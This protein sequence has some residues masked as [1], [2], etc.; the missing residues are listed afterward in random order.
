MCTPINT[1][2]IILCH[3]G[4]LKLSSESGD[5]QFSGVYTFLAKYV[6][7]AEL[8]FK[9]GKGTWPVYLTGTC[10]KLSTLLLHELVLLSSSN[11]TYLWQLLENSTCARSA[12]VQDFHNLFFEFSPMMAYFLLL[13]LQKIQY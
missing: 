4:V 10:S 7:S 12:L 5:L 9:I 6:T 13:K 3:V 1:L 8:L 2:V 11:K